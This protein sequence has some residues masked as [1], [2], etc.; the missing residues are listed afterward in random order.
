MSAPDDVARMLTL[1]PWVLHRPGASHAEIADAFGVDV[2]TVRRDLE[3][4]DFCGLPGLGGGDLFEVTT[5]GDRVVLRMADELARP[6]RPTAREAMRLVLTVDAVAD[7]LD[8]ELPALRSAVT[9]VRTALDIPE[10]TADVVGSDGPDTRSTLRDAVR[11]GWRVRLAYQGRTDTQPVDRE[12]DPWALH[13]V[14]GSWYLQGHDH[15]ASD[16]RTFRLDRIAA[17]EVTDVPVQVAAPDHLEPP[18]YVPGD[19][20]LAVVLDVSPRGR[21]LEDAVTVDSV[22]D[23]DDG[24][25]RLA[26]R[27]DAPGWLARLVL[28]AAGEAAVVSPP[29]L[30]EE[31][32]ATARAALA[33]YEP[34]TSAG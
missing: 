26:L 20:D 30:A 8:E 14:D 17:V 16:R 1:V 7:L 2:A 18:R 5:V 34:G 22:D 6:L 28:M 9:K 33:G 27:T 21:W 23:Q 32:A 3:H 25:A 12:V 24:R 29:S 31:V 4:L 11:E 13:V 15:G 10:S 19:D